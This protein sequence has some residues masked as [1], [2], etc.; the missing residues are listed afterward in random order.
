MPELEPARKPDRHCLL[1]DQG[2][3]RIK[4]IGAMWSARTENWSLDVT[5]FGEGD[6]DD[7]TTA[8]D[9]GVMQPPEEVLLSSVASDERMAALESAI[10]ERFSAKS[11]RLQ[12][13][14][15]TC[16]VKNGY[17]NPDQLGD[18][19]WMAIVGGASHYGLPFV[20]MDIGTASTLD[21]V[22]PDGRHLGGL[23][24]PGPATMSDSLETGTD[25]EVGV[26]GRAGRLETTPGEAQAETSAA[27]Y[28]GIVTAQTGA[29]HQFIDWF[30]DK[31]NSEDEKNLKVL[32]T[33]GAANVIL[34]MSDYQLTHDPLLVFKGML[35]SR[36]GSG[37][38]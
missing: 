16:G 14:P 22:D 20:V 13:A 34:A 15:Q 7:F 6:L 33:G 2:S 36:Y 31:L 8:I 25:M 37:E 24:F 19:R 38:H 9:K 21:A 35:C 4:W 27:I 10:A 26:P 3:S 1:I 18:D 17:R 28:W 30:R 12:S 5:T 23:I 32:I 11:I 29:L